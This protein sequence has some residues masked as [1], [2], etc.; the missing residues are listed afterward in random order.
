[1]KKLFFIYSIL[2]LCSC[3]NNHV[4]RSDNSNDL[5]KSGINEIAPSDLIGKTIEY[6]YG[7][8]I[9]HVTID[10]DSEMHWEAMAGDEKGVKEEEH[11]KIESIDKNKLFITWGE[12]N[13]IGVSQVLDFNKGIVSIKK[14]I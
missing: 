1:M 5:E 4:D 11:Y 8:S 2:I 14:L 3:Q 10:S 12:A 9:Y 13:G 7:E 6:K